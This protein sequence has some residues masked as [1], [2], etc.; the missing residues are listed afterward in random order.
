[1]TTTLHTMTTGADPRVAGARLTIDLDALVSN[2]RVLAERSAP[3]EASAVVKADAYGL[4]AEQ[5][6]RALAGAGCRRFFVALP[7]EGL[8]VRRAAPHAEIYVFNGLFTPEAAAFYH[9][10]R[11]LPVLNSQADLAIWEAHGWDDGDTPR[12]CAVH[13][14]TGMNRLG[15]TPE[16]ARILAQ[17]NALTGALSPRLIISHLSC[18]DDPTHP[19]N[20][21]QLESFQELAALFPDAESSLANSA[22]VFLGSPFLRDT[23]RPG[24]ALYGGAPVGGVANPMRAV[25]TAETRIA[26][27]RHVPAGQSVS[28]GATP[29]VRDTLV[30]VA[31]TGYA[32]GYHRSGSGAGVPLRHAELEGAHGFIGGHRVPVIGRITMD[33]TLFDVTAL[34]AEGVKVGDFIELFGPNMPVDEVAKA[35]GTISYEILTSIG[36]RYERHYIHGE[37]DI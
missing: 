28:Y 22:G 2:Y 3:A 34:G 7:E 14:E 18:G 19:M 6:V 31:S 25:A 24:I 1:M 4:G 15:L 29:V 17:E 16:R 21:R 27:I 10:G 36:R 20:Q 33:L 5:V 32:D 30:A 11:L 9:E 23:T 26:Q 35:T 12:P 13:V 8:A 37:A